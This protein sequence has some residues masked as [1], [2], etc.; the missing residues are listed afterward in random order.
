MVI[1]LAPTLIPPLLGLKTVGMLPFSFSPRGILRACPT[2]NIPPSGL[3]W[4]E[5]DGLRLLPAG[6]LAVDEAID[7][8]MA[9]FEG[10]A[11]DLHLLASSDELRSL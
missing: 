7:F 4:L 5:L 1:L 6:L 3:T 11:V 10:R 2:L 9:L 8:L